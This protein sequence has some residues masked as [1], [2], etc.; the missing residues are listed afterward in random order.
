MRA[1]SNSNNPNLYIDKKKT[2]LKN[3]FEMY[4]YIILCIGNNLLNTYE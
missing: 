3:V 4:K 1:M 2:F